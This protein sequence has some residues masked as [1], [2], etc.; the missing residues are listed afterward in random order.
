MVSVNYL[1]DFAKFRNTKLP[2]DFSKLRYVKPCDC[3]Y[4]FDNSRCSIGGNVPDYYVDIKKVFHE[5]VKMQKTIFGAIIPARPAYYETFQILKPSYLILH[6]ESFA[7]G[8]GTNAIKKVVKESL[9]NPQTQGRVTLQAD[10]IDGKTSPAGFYYKL[11]F[12]F[13]DDNN[14]AI[15]AKWLENGGTKENAPK[16]YGFMYLPKENVEHC[17]NYSSKK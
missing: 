10:M 7:K 2:S 3:V 17:L 15:L 11:G 14:N 4:I 6:L 12:R 13:A 8:Q 5:A 16:L 9:Q 1:T